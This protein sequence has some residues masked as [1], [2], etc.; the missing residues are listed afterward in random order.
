[1]IGD[2]ETRMDGLRQRQQARQ[3]AAEAELVRLKDTLSAHAEDIKADLAAEAKQ[4]NQLISCVGA[5]TRDATNAALRLRHDSEAMR[6]ALKAN[7]AVLRRQARWAWTAVGGACLAAVVILVLAGWA[8]SRLI[9]V[10]RLEADALRAANVD[11]LA[12]AREEGQRAIAD[13]HQQLAAQRAEVE[14]GIEDV[15]AEFAA[16]STERDS[17]QAELERFIYLRDRLGITLV[18]GQ[19]RPVIVVPEGQ[20]IR[21]WGAPGLSNLAR[22]NGRMYRVMAQR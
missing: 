4:I 12:V 17:V 14:R 22:Y 18:E 15:G 16:L 11:E 13:L 20:E 5:Q 1:M 7:D 19:T 10:A 21:A 9:E 2:L 8:A 3:D 6:Q